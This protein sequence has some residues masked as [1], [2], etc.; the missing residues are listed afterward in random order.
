[1]PLGRIAG[2]G[3]QLH[4]FLIAVLDGGEL[5]A[6]ALAA[7]STG[8]SPR[9]PLNRRESGPQNWSASFW[10]EKSVTSAFRCGINR[11]VAVLRRYAA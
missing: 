2:V 7:L 3:I 4:L 1:M 11:I 6:S 9:Y 8:K 10:K 5:L